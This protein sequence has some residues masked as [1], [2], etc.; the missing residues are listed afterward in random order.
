MKSIACCLSLVVAVVTTSLLA[1]TVRAQ[2]D[3]R[4]IDN[5]TH[6]LGAVE[7]QWF[8]FDYAGDK[9][10]ILLTLARGTE[11]GIAFNV[12]TPAQN[13]FEDKPIGR[14]TPS[15]IDCETGEEVYWGECQSED[16]KWAGQFNAGGTYLV[17]VINYNAFAREMTLTIQGDGVTL[18]SNPPAIAPPVLGPPTTLPVTGGDPYE[19]GGERLIR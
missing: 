7:T 19:M 4:Y 16:L 2:S 1:P 10:P 11:S 17:Q 18:K 3:A 15:Q 14:G 8:K 6:A 5:Q 13:R 9:S 12:F